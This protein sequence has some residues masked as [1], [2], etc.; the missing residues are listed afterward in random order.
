[1]KSEDIQNILQR[2][3]QHSQRFLTEKSRMN[4]LSYHSFFHTSSVVNSSIKLCE[5]EGL[6]SSQTSHITLAAWFH[7]H[8]F[9]DEPKDH[10]RVSCDYLRAFLKKEDQKQCFDRE[11]LFSLIMATELNA[12][13]ENKMEEI[14]RDADL[15]YIGSNDFFRQ[16]DLLRQEWSKIMNKH[17]DEIGWLENNIRFLS[18][19]QYYTETARRWYQPLKQKNLEKLQQ[20]LEAIRPLD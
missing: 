3:Q 1:M 7:D 5:G 18:L 15:H 11:V 16:A 20:Q 19:H 8:G 4:F 13:P 14:I 12:Q 6:N 2:A 10:E 9:A 17:F